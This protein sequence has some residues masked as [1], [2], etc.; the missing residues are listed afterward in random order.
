MKRLQ[1]LVRREFWENKGALRTTPIIIGAICI[2][3]TLMAVF[4]TSHVD[5]DLY[6]FKEAILLFAEQPVEFR[7]MAVTQAIL[8]LSVFFTTVLLFVVFFYLLG[9]LYDDR[10][11]RSILF[12][13]SLP[14]SDTVTIASKLVT[15]MVVAPI[16]FLAVLIATQLLIAL[17]ASVMVLIVS[18]NPWS[19]FLG[20]T[21]PFSV[22]G[23][24]GLSYIASAIWALP[25]Y[26][27]LLFVS[28]FAPR[29][30]LLFAI[31]PPVVFSVLQVWIEFLRTFTLKNTLAGLIGKWFTNAPLMFSIGDF[32]DGTPQVT[33]GV[34]ITDDFDHSATVANIFDRL[35]SLQMLVG[36]VIAIV[37]LAGAL[38]LRR[39]ATDN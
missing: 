32:D 7:S 19:L 11:D 10:K 4:T 29:V 34:P 30:P 35:F 5:N 21:N 25:L 3:F 2:G 37:F 12:W 39:R 15:A 13:K 22:W 38:W 28:A 18:E 23:L 26:G 31:L 14:A 24:I 8:V 20:V 33:L 16:A 17:I 36:L 9:A 27:W 1:A 6:T